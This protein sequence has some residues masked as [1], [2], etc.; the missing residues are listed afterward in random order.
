[1]SAAETCVDGTREWT[2]VLLS[3]FGWEFKV[4]TVSLHVLRGFT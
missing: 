3:N 4:V 2:L 1:M